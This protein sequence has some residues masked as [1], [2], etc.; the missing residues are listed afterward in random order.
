M[1]FSRRAFDFPARGAIDNA[2]Q[3]SWEMSLSR[4]TGSARDKLEQSLAAIAA[5]DGSVFVKLYA[6]AARRE[7]DASDKRARDGN[8]LGPLDGKIVSIKDLF[9]VTGEPTL[10]GSIM[11]ANAP[12]VT[13]D[14]IIVKRLRKAGAV[15]IGKTLMT[16]FAFTAVGLNPH[17]PIAGNAVD[18]SRVAGG[19]STGAGVS[20]AD[21]TSEISIGSDT[22]GSIR[23]PAALNGVVGFK[24]T[25]K[26]VPLQGAFPLS[27]SLDSIGPLA[28]SV[29]DCAIADAVMAGEKIVLAEPVSLI[30]IHIAVPGGS[31]LDAMEPAIAE[32]FKTSLSL[33]EKAGAVLVDCILDDLIHEMAEATSVGSIAGIEGSRVHAGWLNDTG[34]DVDPRVQ[35]PLSRR[36][37]V[38]EVSYIDVMQKRQALVRKM[39]QSMASFDLLALPTSPITA[40]LIAAVVEDE[41]VYKRTEGLLLRNPQI[42]NQFDLT[43]ISLPMPGL[44]LPGGL[45]LFARHG[46][47]RRLLSMALSIER[48]LL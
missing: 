38:S 12:A 6:D 40:P 9:D 32:A 11:R 3:A 27:P 2:I 37:A 10:A 39:D 13:S 34:L 29:T 46:A 33:S 25:A 28:R 19:S 31:V 47:D 14:A 35:R 44:A 26:R 17:Y 30:G 21:G 41:E 16:E 5:R 7:A 48:L 20:V 15:I 36:L 42:A 43:A 1:R 22:G 8:L 4:S 23:I 45:M 24:P 18:P